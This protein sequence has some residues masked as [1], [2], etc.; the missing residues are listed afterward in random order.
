VGRRRKAVRGKLIH[1][2]YNS[3]WHIGQQCSTQPRHYERYIDRLLVSKKWYSEAWVALLTSTPVAINDYDSTFFDLNPQVS[4]AHQRPIPGLSL[5]TAVHIASLDQAARFA[6]VLATQCPRLRK[7]HIKDIAVSLSSL[8]KRFQ[9][10]ASYVD[11]WL[12][13]WDAAD[14][15][16]SQWFITMTI[17]SGLKSVSMDISEYDNNKFFG[18][19][20]GQM[21][22]VQA[23]VDLAERLFVESATRPYDPAA[24]REERPVCRLRVP[25]RT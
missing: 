5:V 10:P 22:V 4:L 18:Y 19:S 6:R 23:N 13:H 12:C 2:L 17:F 8:S 24:T 25:K 7:L 1:F 14:I 20:S 11:A 9:Y 3:L 16:G 21:R 15:R